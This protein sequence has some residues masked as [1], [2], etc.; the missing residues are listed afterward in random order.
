ME[1]VGDTSGSKVV[2]DNKDNSSASPFFCSKVVGKGWRSPIEI[3]F[4]TLVE[5]KRECPWDWY[6]ALGID[7][8]DASKIRRG[9]VIPFEEL[10]IKIANYFGVDSYTIWKAED[11]LGWEGK[12]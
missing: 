4:Q 10:R 6:K 7:K 1:K 8:G 3:R 12:R 2:L 5:T 9:L 11:V